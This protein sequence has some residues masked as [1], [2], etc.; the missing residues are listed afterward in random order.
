MNT[1]IFPGD[2]GLALP[3]VELL[4]NLADGD[5]WMQLKA[6]FSVPEAAKLGRLQKAARV[7]LG[8]GLL[9]IQRSYE[10]LKTVDHLAAWQAS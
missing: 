10:I 1:G 6:S 4:G 7:S 3:V 5:A 9:Q 8:P 2:M